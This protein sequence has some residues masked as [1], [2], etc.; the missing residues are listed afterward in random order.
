[1]TLMN[2][3]KHIKNTSKY[4]PSNN[5]CENAFKDTLNHTLKIHFKYIEYTWKHKLLNGLKV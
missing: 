2:T 4:I 3:I 5:P 1:M